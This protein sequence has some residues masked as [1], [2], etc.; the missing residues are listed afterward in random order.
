M[1]KV[2]YHE[3]ISILRKLVRFNV[4]ALSDSEFSEFDNLNDTINALMS[5][6]LK[7]KIFF[8]SILSENENIQNLNT[9]ISSVLSKEN[10]KDFTIVLLVDHEKR[11]D[12]ID[13]GLRPHIKTLKRP[14]SVVDFKNFLIDSD[15]KFFDIGQTTCGY[16][17]VHNSYLDFFNEGAVDTYLKIGEE[18]FVKIIS[19][20]VMYNTDLIEKVVEK[21][22]EYFF[23]KIEDFEVL[24]KAVEQ[25]MLF[26]FRTCRRPVQKEQMA[27]KVNTLKEMVSVLGIKEHVINE[28]DAVVYTSI[29][30][31]KRDKAIS[32]IK[33]LNELLK[34]DGGFLS[35]HSLMVSYIAS[36]IVMENGWKSD[37]TLKKMAMTGL[38][39]D[40]LLE[41]D[42]L[43]YKVDV[44]NVMMNQQ[45]DKAQEKLIKNHS[46]KMSEIISQSSFIL[47]EV[48][49][50]IAQHHELPDGKGFPRNLNAQQ[51]IPLAGVFIV[52][53]YFVS[54]VHGREISIALL[55]EIKS[56]MNRYF[57]VGNFKQ[58]LLGINQIIDRAINS[59]KE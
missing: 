52:A 53:E 54:H 42:E 57:D 47:P 8:V 37:S 55:T 34:T 4:E 9:F 33:A 58:A 36:L 16:V 24:K 15:F 35:S 43:S 44:E 48:A 7:D 20:G 26:M 29:K 59:T 32:S 28:L 2:F 27:K 5:R 40:L 18:K 31:I 46:Y 30:E 10:S 23:V 25:H 38:L 56:Q 39:H 45:V 1:T 41:S 6:E 14:Y 49:T 51:V 22:T 50:I 12:S 3:P 19:K 11:I 17:K 13:P 21:G